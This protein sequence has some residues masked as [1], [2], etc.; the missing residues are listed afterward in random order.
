MQNAASELYIVK[1][2]H[3]IQSYLNS[4]EQL[5][6]NLKTELDLTRHLLYRSWLIQQHNCKIAS[7]KEIMPD[8]IEFQTKKVGSQNLVLTVQDSMESNYKKIANQLKELGLGSQYKARTQTQKYNTSRLAYDHIVTILGN[9]PYEAFYLMLLDNSTQ[10]IK[11]VRISEGGISGTLV[12][13]KKVYKIALDNYTSN[14]ILAH[15][16]PSGNL[17]PSYQDKEL[18]KKI[19]DAGKLLDINVLDH[20]VIGWDNYFSFADEGMIL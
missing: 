3:E 16:H 9:L 12:D 4:V 20:L 13:L 10:L 8:G 5:A 1:K 15:N 2:L 6:Y 19:S 18:T 14:L 17:Q 11:T 7:P